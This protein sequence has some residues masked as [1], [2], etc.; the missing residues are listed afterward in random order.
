MITGDRKQEYLD[1]FNEILNLDLQ[2]TDLQM[3][4]ELDKDKIGRAHV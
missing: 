2:L 3:L 4:T 1:F